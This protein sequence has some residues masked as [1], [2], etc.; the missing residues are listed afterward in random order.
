MF[1]DAQ[2]QF[3]ASQAITA[4][5]VSTNVIDL[6]VAQDLGIAISPHLQLAIYATA[7]FVSAGGATLQI[8]LQSSA[9]NSTFYTLS[10]TDVF[11]VATLPINTKIPMD[12]VRRSP[13]QST[14]AL[15]PRYLQLNYVV[16]TSTFSAG[17][18]SAYLVIDRHDND[19]EQYKNGYTVGS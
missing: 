1:T 4:T 2:L 19:I 14:V 18:L 12:L 8:Q 16:G 6:G 10:Q 5:A 11:A 9:D 13:V 17:K 15:F 3:S 7:A